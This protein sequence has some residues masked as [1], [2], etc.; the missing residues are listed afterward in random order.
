MDDDGVD[1][2]FG[3]LTYYVA[4]TLMLG[5]ALLVLAIEAVACFR[6]WR[7]R[8]AVVDRRASPTSLTT[9]LIIS[10]RRPAMVKKMMMTGA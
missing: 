9:I 5:S 8:R 3:A 4:L 7:S 2:V 6:R 10:S 1:S